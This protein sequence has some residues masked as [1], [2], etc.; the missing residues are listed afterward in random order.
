LLMPKN[1][2]N[3]PYVMRID[4]AN[5]NPDEIAAYLQDLLQVRYALSKKGLGISVFKKKKFCKTKKVL[6]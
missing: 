2:V 6:G 5:K 4:L 1:T 3:N